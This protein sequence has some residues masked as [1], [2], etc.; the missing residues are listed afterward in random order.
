MG[1]RAGLNRCGKSRP[2]RNSIP[3]RP[4]RG[5][6]LYRLSYSDPLPFSYRELNYC[7]FNN[8]VGVF[9]APYELSTPVQVMSVQAVSLRPL[10]AEISGSSPSHSLRDL[11]W[12]K[13]FSRF[14]F[15]FFFF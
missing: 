12:T 14:S 10:I 13:K 8:R 1:P 15:F 3:N 4:V 6:S 9:V 11:F 7:F 2:H 5:E